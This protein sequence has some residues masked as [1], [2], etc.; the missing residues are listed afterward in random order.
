MLHNGIE[1]G[2][3]SIICEVRSILHDH[4]G[5]D[6]EKIAEIFK[7][8]STE[9][10]LRGNFLIDIGYKGRAAPFVL[11]KSQVARSLADCSPRLST[12]SASPRET[13][14]TPFLRERA[15]SRRSRTRSLRTRT[16]VR[17]QVFGPSR[18]VRLSVFSLSL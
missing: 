1:Q 10:E 11:L 6:D 4:L 13:A 9:G 18:C 3:L 7:S 12:A 14:S 8:W 15:S 2:C 5:L 16:I 17:G